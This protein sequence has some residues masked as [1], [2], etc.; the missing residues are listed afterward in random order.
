MKRVGQA[1]RLETGE[2][3]ATVVRQ[4]C[5]FSGKTVFARKDVSWLGEAHPPYE[6]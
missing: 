4:N 3:A 6:H 1:S 5:F 2:A